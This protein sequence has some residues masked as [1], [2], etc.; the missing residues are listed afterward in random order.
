VPAFCCRD[1]WRKKKGKP[2]TS[3]RS[4]EKKGEKKGGK[5][6]RLVYYLAGFEWG[7]GGK[8]IFTCA[9]E[10]EGGISFLADNKGL[11]ICPFV[12]RPARGKREKKAVLV[13]YLRRGE[14][15]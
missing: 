8:M 11:P 3:T 13:P 10:G 1:G 12:P 9:R 15:G 4:E 7:G 5:K 2:K 6:R 14:E